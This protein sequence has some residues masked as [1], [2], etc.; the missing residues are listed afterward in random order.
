MTAKPLVLFVVGLLLLTA[1]CMLATKWILAGLESTRK[2]DDVP[3]HPLA[4]PVQVPPSPR[5]QA[6]PAEDIAD[7]R[8]IES[9]LL[10]SYQWIDRDQGIVRIPVE[11]A[12]ELLVEREGGQ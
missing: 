4:E 9:E 10:G 5:L 12:M 3:L 1:G 7:H 6:T 8:A 11:R 2:M